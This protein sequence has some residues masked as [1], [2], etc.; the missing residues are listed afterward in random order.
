MRGMRRAT[1]RCF[2]CGER[3]LLAEFY[4]HP[5]MKDGRL[6]K[7]KVCAKRD[8]V[9]NRAGKLKQYH[10]YDRYRSRSPKR[11]AQVAESMRRQRGANPEKYKARTAVGNAL[12]DGCLVLGPCEVCGDSRVQAHHDDYS[13]PLEVRWFCFLHHREQMH[14]QVVTAGT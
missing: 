8:V 13:K 5:Q 1:K 4:R 6:N 14:G 7:C 10:D 3:K 12:R 9:A 11:K 2:K